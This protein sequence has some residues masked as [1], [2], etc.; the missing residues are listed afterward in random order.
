MKW[1]RLILVFSLISGLAY[2]AMGAP[3]ESVGGSDVNPEM[4]DPPVPALPIR[5][6]YLTDTIDITLRSGPGTDYKILAMLPLGQK[7]D[8][9]A[10]EDQWSKIRT[11]AGREGWVA[12]RLI[13]AAVP[14]R[15]RYEQLKEEHETL[16]AERDALKKNNDQLRKENRA[17]EE[18]LG[19]RVEQSDDRLSE[20]LEEN[21]RLRRQADRQVLWWF[22]AGAGVLL[23]GILMGRRSRKEKR[24]PYFK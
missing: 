16:V 2:M 23:L 10:R 24:R 17:L 5:S 7:I 20:L 6:A 9:L 1:A 12:N 8:I 14:H 19:S 11:A 22:L 15:V 18:N 4:V 21:R 3:E 13:D